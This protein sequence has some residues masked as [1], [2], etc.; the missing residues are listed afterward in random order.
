MKSGECERYSAAIALPCLLFFLF[1]FGFLTIFSPHRLR[2]RIGSSRNRCEVNSFNQNYS[3]H[4]VIILEC[5]RT[6]SYSLSLPLSLMSLYIVF[7]SSSLKSRRRTRVKGR[8]YV[9]NYTGF[10]RTRENDDGKRHAGYK[11]A[12]RCV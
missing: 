1:F 12:T 8:K 10:A 6:S 3:F 11:G 9:R 4:L 7:F 5:R 2:T